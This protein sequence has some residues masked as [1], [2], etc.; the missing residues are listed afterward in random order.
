[1]STRRI[2][3]I[4]MAVLLVGLPGVAAARPQSVI[5]SISGTVDSK[6]VKSGTYTVRV[7]DVVSGQVVKTEPLGT[8]GEFKFT[9]LPLGHKYLVELFDTSLSKVVSTLGPF[10]LSTAASVA[11]TGVVMSS[12]ATMAAAVPAAAWLLAAG[13]GTAAA[14]ATATESASR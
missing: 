7:R 6:T 11:V 12:A 8:Q 3:A 5:G 10:A 2:L 9:E 14:V 13:A 4:A 1:M